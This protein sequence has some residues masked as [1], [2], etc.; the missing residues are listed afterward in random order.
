MSR[1]VGRG[2]G[3]S[4]RARAVLL[5]AAV[6][7]VVGLIAALGWRFVVPRVYVDAVPPPTDGSPADTAYFRVFDYLHT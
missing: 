6:G 1:V 4:P 2:E 7:L 5:P 3:R